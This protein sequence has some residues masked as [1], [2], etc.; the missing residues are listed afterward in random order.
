MLLRIGRYCVKIFAN[1]IVLSKTVS[2]Q[3]ESTYFFMY[4]YLH[5]EQLIMTELVSRKWQKSWRFVHLSAANHQKRQPQQAHTKVVSTEDNLR[6]KCGRCRCRAM[7][8]HTKECHWTM[9]HR[10]NQNLQRAVCAHAHT[11]GAWN[12]MASWKYYYLLV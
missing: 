3:S 12:D 10:P 1:S 7:E 9:Q 4:I 8:C 5:Y 2:K 6:R 11:V